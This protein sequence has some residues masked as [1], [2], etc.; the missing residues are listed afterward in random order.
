MATSETLAF[1]VGKR[2]S[3][4]YG[5]MRVIGT[6]V[7]DVHVEL[8]EDIFAPPSP[9]VAK[10]R[11]VAFQDFDH[12]VVDGAAQTPVSQYAIDVNATT[13]HQEVEA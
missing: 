6:V 13:D 1:E 4:S 11:M 7:S 2:Y 8:F 5:G 10:K 12:V 3:F 9:L